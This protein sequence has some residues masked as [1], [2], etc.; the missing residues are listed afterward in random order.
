[1]SFLCIQESPVLTGDSGP[2]CLLAGRAGMTEKKK[3][4]I[5]KEKEEKE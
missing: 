4:N 1:V 2:A 5:E 3:M